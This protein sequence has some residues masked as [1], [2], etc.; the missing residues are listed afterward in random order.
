MSLWEPGQLPHTSPILKI[1]DPSASVSEDPGCW[2]KTESDRN[3]DR[4]AHAH[5]HTRTHKVL[6]ARNRSTDKRG[7]R[8][9]AKGERVKREVVVG[10]LVSRQ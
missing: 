5:T 1:N 7:K 10:G 2:Q 3:N 6:N 8:R 9:E 4:R